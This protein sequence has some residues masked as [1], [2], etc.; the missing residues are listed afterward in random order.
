[1][2]D[3][4]ELLRVLHEHALGVAR[5]LRRSALCATTVKLKLRWPDFTT[6]TRQMTLPQ[7]T[8]AGEQIYALAR[9]LFARLWKPGQPVRLLGVGVSGLTDQPRQIGLFDR[10]DERVE[11]LTA[12]VSAMRARFGEK[13]IV[14]G[15]DMRRR[16]SDILGKDHPGKDHPST[17]NPGTDR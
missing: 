9:Q 2:S 11:K 4:A 6:P 12:A 7:A 17:D 3:E 10:P 1:V 16:A 5:E 14:R 15:S 13:A 8:D